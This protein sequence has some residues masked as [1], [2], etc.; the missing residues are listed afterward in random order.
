M[1]RPEDLLIGRGQ[2]G[3]DAERPRASKPLSPP[4]ETEVP[5]HRAQPG[6][7]AGGAPD[8]EAADPAHIVAPQL[9]AYEDE[10]VVDPIGIA[11]EEM[12]DLQD[13]GSVIG[14]EPIPGSLASLGRRGLQPPGLS[15]NGRSYGPHR[16]AGWRSN[17]ESG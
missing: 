10:A 8:L 3:D 15:R 4:V 2:P 11:L 17:L 1:D 13:Q 12:N 14:E 16:T 9:L 7:E 6:R 5:D